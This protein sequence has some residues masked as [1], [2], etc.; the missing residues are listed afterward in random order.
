MPLLLIGALGALVGLAAY[1]VFIAQVP[2][3]SLVPW[4]HPSV[5]TALS[6]TPPDAAT[7]AALANQ[8][9][10]QTAPGPK[11]I[12]LP[13]AH[14]S[15]PPPPVASPHAAV[16]RVVG[17]ANP[18]ATT[19]AWAAQVAATAKTIE[20]G[21]PITAPDQVSRIQRAILVGF[22]D[23]LQAPGGATRMKLQQTVVQLASPS[24]GPDGN[25]AGVQLQPLL[26]SAPPNA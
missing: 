15:P 1:E 7:Q 5:G 4:W 8:A 13:F 3:S 16:L 12:A 24:M 11:I 9:V 17:L 18:D 25:A 14:S 2:L 26:S 23:N 22:L 10:N 20:N 6:N 21:L 19:A